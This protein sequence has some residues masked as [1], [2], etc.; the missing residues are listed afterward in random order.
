MSRSFEDGVLNDELLHVCNQTL[1]GKKPLNWSK[2]I[3]ITFPKKGDLGIP[4]NYGGISLTCIAAKIYNMILLH[5]IQS[6]IE[7]IFRDNQNDFR[8]GRSTVGHILTLRRL[9]EGIKAKNRTAVLTFIDFRQAFDPIQ[10]KKML[11]ILRAYGIPRMIVNA[12][13]VMYNNALAK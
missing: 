8:P 12:V 6:P 9:M 5:H 3:I 1:N 7:N 11:K 13:T 4:K 2:R 10:N